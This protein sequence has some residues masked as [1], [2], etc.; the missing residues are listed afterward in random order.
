MER[1]GKRIKTCEMDIK[2]I[3]NDL[4]PFKCFRCRIEDSTRGQIREGKKWRERK[5]I[6]DCFISMDGNLSVWKHGTG[7]KQS[8]GREDWKVAIK[9]AI[10]RWWNKAWMCSAYTVEQKS[11]EQMWMKFKF[12][13][14]VTWWKASFTSNTA[15]ITQ[16]QDRGKETRTND[17]VNKGIRKEGMPFYSCFKCVRKREWEERRKERQREKWMD[18]KDSS[19]QTDFLQIIPQKADTIILIRRELC[20]NKTLFNLHGMFKSS[21]NQSLIQQALWRRCEWFKKW[22]LM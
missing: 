12:L 22:I 6:R 10:Q 2:A 19:P 5:P 20:A 4:L 8:N 16:K 7:R 17:I 13:S 18:G 21:R 15:N 3:L 11:V 9:C 14:R 1:N